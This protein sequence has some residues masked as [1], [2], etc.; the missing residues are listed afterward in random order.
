MSSL[1]EYLRQT[2]G[3]KT[4]GQISN[5]SGIDKGYLSKIERNERNP[6]PDMLENLA[7]AYGVEYNTLLEICGYKE[8]EP[9][10][11]RRL[12]KGVSKATDEQQE[13]M[14]ELLKESFSNLFDEDD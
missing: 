4:L 8:E 9:I 7:R 3:E 5:I 10:I 6:K 14:I 12:R 2:R 11:I 1:G 13:K